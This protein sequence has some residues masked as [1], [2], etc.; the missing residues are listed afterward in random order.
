MLQDFLQHYKDNEF[1]IWKATKGNQKPVIQMTAIRK[2]NDTGGR[3]DKEQADLFA[4]NP[5]EAFQPVHR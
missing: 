5:T 3:N 2:Y 1:K 4:E